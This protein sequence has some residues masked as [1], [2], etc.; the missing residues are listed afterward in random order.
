[1]RSGEPVVP[2]LGPAESSGFRPPTTSAMN[3]LRKRPE[4]LTHTQTITAPARRRVSAMAA[5]A[6]I[7]AFGILYSSV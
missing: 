6:A 7:A 2:Y 3:Y 5:A 1:M 4:G